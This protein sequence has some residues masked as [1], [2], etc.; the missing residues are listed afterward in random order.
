MLL[1][2]LYTNLKDNLAA[3]IVSCEL[4]VYAEKDHRYMQAFIYLFSMNIGD[5]FMIRIF[6][7]VLTS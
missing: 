5:D 6:Q 3:Y 1:D 4:F 7:K 2:T